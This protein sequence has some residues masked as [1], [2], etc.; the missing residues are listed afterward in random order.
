MQTLATWYNVGLGYHLLH[1]HPTGL[2]YLVGGKKTSANKLAALHE[3]VSMCVHAHTES[4]AN[5]TNTGD[6][7]E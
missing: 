7:G 1:I 6:W 2:R 5:T 3:L 4:G